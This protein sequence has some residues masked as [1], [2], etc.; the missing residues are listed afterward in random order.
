MVALCLQ[1]HKEA[2]GGAFTI[3]QLRLLKAT[4]PAGPVRGRFN[5]QRKRLFIIGGSNFFV[6]S[7]SILRYGNRD[8]IWFGRSKEGYGT[9]N[10]DLFSPT[11]EL[12]LSMRDNDWVTLPSVDD[13]ESPPSAH[14]LIVRSKAHSISLDVKFADLS[15]QQV[16]SRARQVF[17]SIY[18]R[19]S[20]IPIPWPED[21]TRPAQRDPIEQKVDSLQKFVREHLGEGPITTCELNLEIQFPVPLKLTPMKLETRPGAS[22][23]AFSG[24]LMGSAIVLHLNA[25]T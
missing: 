2:D 8:L 9:L 22:R 6:G 18:S 16:C 21:L 3:K 5:W 11:G 10:M 19:S 24:C 13:L 1:H 20:A 12:V 25:S 4:T 14:R 23:F 15:L 17:T 7:P